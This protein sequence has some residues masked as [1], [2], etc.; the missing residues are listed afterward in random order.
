MIKAALTF[1]PEGK[2]PVLLGELFIKPRTKAG[3]I[4]SYDDQVTMGTMTTPPV[5]IGISAVN[6]W[7]RTKHT[8]W[9]LVREALEQLP[10]E[11][12]KQ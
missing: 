1:T 12:R 2:D 5:D 6:S 3:T 8:V 11:L 4:I 9:E 7:N 10:V